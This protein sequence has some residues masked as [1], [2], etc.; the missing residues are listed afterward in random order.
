M[1]RSASTW[2][3]RALGVLVTVSLGLGTFVLYGA[4]VAHPV[5]AAEA[6]RGFTERPSYAGRPGLDAALDGVRPAA[7]VYRY[8]TTGSARVDLLGIERH[9]P[10]TTARVV[11]LGPGCQ[12]EE[13]VPLFDEHVETYSACAAAGDQ[14]E[15]GYATRLTYFFVPDISD[16]G[17]APGGSRTGHR[18]APG[19]TQRFRCLDRARQ[20]RTDGSITFLGAST[21][22]VDGREQP[23]R[24][25]RMLTVLRG[26]T[27]GAALRELCTE[28]STGLVLRETRTVGLTVE[29]AFVGVVRYVESAEFTLKSM[30]PRR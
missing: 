14:I 18:L 25:V 23:C 20:V 19:S 29:S 21:V 28:A 4:R 3:R 8:A 12:W 6:L 27:S 5:S 16:A 2:V 1:P 22:H 15:T 11:R 26:R 9:Y 17:C 7:G 10:S 30:T 13:Q 24:Q